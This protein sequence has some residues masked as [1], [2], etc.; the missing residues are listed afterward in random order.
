MLE[1]NIYHIYNRGNN[2]ENIFFEEK[3]YLFFL[4]RFRFYL[5]DLVKVYSFCLMPNHFHILLE[6]KDF[7]DDKK[8][9]YTN[10]ELSQLEKAFKGFFMSYSKAIN[11]AFDRTG[12]LF[13]KKF[14]RK[15]IHDENYLKSIVAYIHLNPV[16]ADLVNSAELWPYS[17]YKFFAGEQINMLN[18]DKNEVL[19]WFSGKHNFIEFHK[20]YREFQKDR[21]YLFSEQ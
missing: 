11:K 4:Q 18:I 15:I 16:R 13:Q 17:S 12:S 8:I 10:K 7:G 19:S 20:L 5:C 21:D 1:N 2:K 6:V 3:N 14:K 9:N